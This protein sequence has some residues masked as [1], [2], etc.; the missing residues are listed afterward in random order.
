MTIKMIAWA[1]LGLNRTVKYVI[2]SK[3]E[4]K[5]WRDGCKQENK[6]RV[7]DMLD[8]MSSWFMQ[9]NSSIATCQINNAIRKIDSF[10]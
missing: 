10:L 7:N 2:L 1:L 5:T 3:I 8:F 6:I 9:V 4:I